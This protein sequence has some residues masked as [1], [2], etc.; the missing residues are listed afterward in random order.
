[1]GNSPRHRSPGRRTSLSLAALATGSA[2]I[3]SGVMLPGGV[4]AAA[5]PPGQDF[6]V[7][8][9]DLEFI[10]KQIDIS[11]AH[12]EDTLTNPDSSPLCKST[13]TFDVSEQTHYDLD[14]DPCVGSPLLPFGLRTVDGRWNN[15][16]PGQDGYGTA[17]TTFP[18]LLEADYKQAEATPPFAPGN[19]SPTPGPMTSYEQ[20]DGFVYDS[21]PRTISNLIVDQ[22]TSNPAAVS[23]A[24]RI[25]GASVEGT[26]EARRTAGLDRYDTAAQISKANFAP[27]VPVVYLA[28]GENFPDALAAGPAASAGNGPLLLV[29]GGGIPQ[30]T[31]D[32]L[33]RL[34]P[35]RIVVVGGD[36]IVS[37]GV[38]DQLTSSHPEATVERISG[39]TRFETAAQLS[40]DAFPDGANKVYIAFGHNFPDALAAAAPAARD[41]H[42]ILL[43]NTED[44]PA[45]T[46]A[47]LTRLS[48]SEIVV[49]GGAATI[50]SQVE[51]DLAAYANGGTVTRLGGETRYETAAMISAANY[52]ESTSEVWLATGENFPDALA[53][54]PAAAL[55]KAPILLVPSGGAIPASVA[56]EIARLSP[57][58]INV[59]GGTA[60]VSDAIQQE[61][62]ALT[63]GTNVFIPDIATD[64][65]LSAS[66]TSL[67]VIF[68]QF[69]DHG[70][71]L[72]EKGGNGTIVVPLKEDDPLYVEGSRT[73]FLTLSRAT[74]ADGEGRE[75]TNRT[76]PFVDQ[77]QTYGSHAAHNAFMRQYEVGPDGSPQPTGR[78]LNGV[79]GGLPTWNDVKNQARDV[80]G[81]EMDDFDA[82][83]VPLLATDPYGH[84]ILGANGQAQI[85]DEGGFIEGN[86]D[87]PVATD[88][89]T[90]N[91]SFLDD[92]A[93]GATP[94]PDKPNPDGGPNIPGY[95]NVALG[96][97][98]ITGDGRGNE[99][100]GLTSV[101]HVFHAEHNRMM[102][103]I[104]DELQT[105]PEELQARYE[106]DGFWDYGERLFQAARFMTE[107]QYQHLVFEEFARRIAPSIDAVVLNENSYQPQVNSAINAEFAH[108][109]YRFGH[110]MLR[111]TLPREVNGEMVDIPLFDAFLNPKAYG[112]A[113]DGS[114]LSGEEAAGSVLKGLAN[115]TAN[116]I[117]EFVT[118]TL[119]NQLL[120]LPLDLPAINMMRARDTGTPG[121][122][123]A[124][125]TFFEQS[126]DPTLQPYESWEDFRLS[127]KNPESISN[128]IAAYGIHPSVQEATTLK[129]KRAAGEALA[130]DA[131]F[132][133]APAAETGLDDV[134][135]WMG[136]LA[137]KPYIFGGMLGATF[138]YV[139]EKQLEDLQNGDRFYYLT[140]NL[141]NTLFHSLEANSLSQLVIRNTTA[142]RVPHDVFA[143][144]QLTFDLD[145]PQAD[146]NA[147]GLTGSQA[148]GWRFTGAEHVTIQDN[149]QPSTIRGGLG[150]D[151]I[152]GK[153]GNDRLEGDDGIDAL[154]GGDGNDI[155]TDLFGD[156]D[157]LQGEAGNDALNPGPGIADLTFGGSGKDFMLG[158]HDGVTAHGGLGDDFMLGSTGRDTM[159]GDEG[160]DWLE[161]GGNADLLQGDMGNTLFNDPN[162]YHGGHDVIISNGGNTDFDAE[163]GDD[164]MIAGPG[165]ERFS[166]VLGFDWV[167]YKNQPNMVNAD[168]GFIVGMPQDL[169]GIRD[170]Y[171]QTEALSGGNGNDILRGSQ[172]GIDLTFG[173]EQIG[174]GH[175]LTQ[176][177]L[178]RIAGLRDLLGGGTVPEYARPFLKDDPVSYDGDVNNNIIIG[179][180]GS[181]LIEPR[182]GRN[183]VDGDAWLN[184]RV[185]HRPAGGPVES[186]NSMSAF[187]TRV[188]RGQI[189]PGDL[190][191]VREIKQLEN[192]SGV[193]DTAVF[194]GIREDYTITELEPGVFEVS[195]TLEAP[196]MANVVRNI[197]RLKFNDSVVC[198]PLGTT[199]NCGQAEGEVVLNYTDPITEDGTLTT[200]ASGVTDSDGI[201]SK[202]TYSLQILTEAGTDPFTNMWVTTQANE[203]GKFT[204]GDAEV[205]FPVRVLV[206]YVDGAGIHEQIASDATAEVA[207]VN[208]AP[209]GL[210]IAPANPSVGDIL[211]ISQQLEDADGAESVLEEPGGVYTWQQSADGTTWADIPGATGNGATATTFIVTTAQQDHQIRLTISYTDDRGQAETARSNATGIVPSPANPPAA[212]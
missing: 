153:G 101:H 90:A 85:A 28:T 3:L 29:T 170:R 164:V 82:L 144:P 112:T 189:N 190:H 194:E 21:Q 5:P 114:A 38:L 143:A 44:I 69:F 36:G 148:N 81:F 4:A 61:A 99:N 151:S 137:E 118:D 200:D 109:V 39:A 122:Q 105:M 20:T 133:N 97:H 103:Q 134:D 56:A 178:D 210:T 123:A 149:D 17:G 8:Q 193:I 192:Q 57:Q 93:H 7:S 155:V 183:F 117:D 35:E 195:N 202:L 34:Q 53:A 209:T 58:R 124:R 211:R 160:N 92:I 126:G 110:S 86:R 173:D 129:T 43:V 207:N 168:M 52:D 65:G 127:M 96:E 197:E 167:S 45:P 165:T 113:P 171:L 77:N 128:F 83:D 132:M 106:A 32:E 201:D 80:L 48:P 150:D 70:L 91:V 174:Y 177:H 89:E 158:G 71:D 13:S 31:A 51:T 98:F 130:A 87:N 162:L 40:A 136:G 121:L 27:N 191:I 107:M 104:H 1:M 75:H 73:N 79:N 72:V 94:A 30:A 67:F 2:V 6:N 55:K 26:G 120:G 119:R 145:S 180:L 185:E 84:L 205:G 54:I 146:L 196:E 60:T 142:D 16:M 156:G 100:I 188:F 187:T 147:A 18:R 15:L 74:I 78:I 42:P 95:D 10:I 141:G 140:R 59:L 204:L 172:G 50:S 25:E 68:G 199:G 182:Q 154:M 181:D 163:G 63:T 152:W 47:E 169:T 33:A 206:T 184:V 19:N 24:E 157:R 175:D 102:E 159:Y 208:D 139:F 64:E 11:E 161:G 186:A 108:V 41:G 88:G 115:Q 125:A 198:L 116:G 179:G 9:G 12:A 203:T 111:E 22:T 14:G 66:A 76:T 135:F 23:A 62:Q 46:A 138:N 131:D 176:E 166:G 49:L 212:E 37:N